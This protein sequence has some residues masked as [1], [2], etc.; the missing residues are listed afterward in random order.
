MSRKADRKARRSS[1]RAHGPRGASEREGKLQ[2][3]EEIPVLFRCTL[4]NVIYDV[5]RSR[6]SWREV[7]IVP[8][9]GFA[10]VVN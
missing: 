8:A 3:R 9:L 5:L 4:R 7:G 10:T 2:R 6:P 1:S